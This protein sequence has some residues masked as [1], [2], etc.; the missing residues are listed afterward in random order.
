MFIEFYSNLLKVV[1]QE[2]LRLIT[3]NLLLDG[4]FFFQKPLL[5]SKF[6]EKIGKSFG[7]SFNFEKMNR[8]DCMVICIF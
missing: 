6:V 3:V 4:S 8:K 1:W 5:N 7:T 2:L